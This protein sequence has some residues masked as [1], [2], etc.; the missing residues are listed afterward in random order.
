MSIDAKIKYEA[1]YLEL[2][3]L[4]E[5]ND[6]AVAEH[7]NK[8]VVYETAIQLFNDKCNALLNT[9]NLN[10]MAGLISEYAA[11][12]EKCCALHAIA[13]SIKTN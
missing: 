11:L 10:I 9:D 2:Q 1:K 13:H 7:L 3:L 4:I 5:T 12:V 8:I 6:A